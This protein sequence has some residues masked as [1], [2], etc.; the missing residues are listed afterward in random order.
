MTTWS[1]LPLPLPLRVACVCAGVRVGVRVCARDAVLQVH[2][3][4][5]GGDPGHL[6]GAEGG[7]QEREACSG[8]RFVQV[9]QNVSQG[10]MQ[11]AGTCSRKSSIGSG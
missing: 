1:A 2:V 7:L 4:G 8:V 3:P 9:S 10:L 6:E 11:R 5:G